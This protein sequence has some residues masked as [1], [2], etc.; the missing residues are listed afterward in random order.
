[1]HLSEWVV[2]QQQ[3]GCPAGRR[4]VVRQACAMP[5]RLY[6]RGVGDSWYRRFMQRHP[7]LAP[8]TSQ[9]FVDTN[10]VPTS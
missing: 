10:D 6:S 9:Y 2:G 7:S 4:G 1:M 8:R 5:E 3:V